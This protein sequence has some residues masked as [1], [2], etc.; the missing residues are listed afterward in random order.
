M[1]GENLPLMLVSSQPSF[2]RL[3]IVQTLCDLPSALGLTKTVV[4][5]HTVVFF[6]RRQTGYLV[7]EFKRHMRTNKMGSIVVDDVTKLFFGFGRVFQFQQYADVSLCILPYLE[8][9]DFVVYPLVFW[10]VIVEPG[11]EHHG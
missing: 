2:S 8:L 3:G 5:R 6:A 9:V 11:I 1:K 7:Y 10:I 4:F